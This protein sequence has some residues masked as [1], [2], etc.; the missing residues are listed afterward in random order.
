V[1]LA[2]GYPF[3]ASQDAAV[4]RRD[5]EYYSSV[6]DKNGPAM[7]WSLSAVNYLVNASDEMLGQQL[8]LRAYSQYVRQPFFIWYETPT[9][10]T[11]NFITG[12]GGFLQVFVFVLFHFSCFSFS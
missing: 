6:T 2:S 5:L 12:A 3:D 1:I 11:S 9:G 10:G 8:M 7:T 4:T